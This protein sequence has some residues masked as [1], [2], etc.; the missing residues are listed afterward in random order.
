MAA[1]FSRRQADGEK[2]VEELIKERFFDRII[3]RYELV[4]NLRV[5]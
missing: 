1:R 3:K 4:E 2:P 5:R